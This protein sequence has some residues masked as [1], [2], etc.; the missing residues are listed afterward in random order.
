MKIAVCGAGAW[1]T[2]LALHLKRKQH[3]VHL[4]PRRMEHAEAIR[5]KEENV[6][7]LPG[8]KIPE[9]LPIYCQLEKLPDF[10]P[11]CIILACPSAGLKNLVRKLAEEFKNGTAP[12]LVSLAKGLDH[13]SLMTPADVIHNAWPSAAGGALSGPTFAGEV[14]EGKPTAIVL[15]TTLTQEKAE[16]F[17]KAINSPELRVYLSSDVAGVELGGCLKNIY[18]IAAGI[19][20]GLGLGD[21]ARAALITR[22][23]NEMIMLGCALGGKRETFFG[24]SGF[25]DLVA[26]CSGD[27][28]RNR[29]FGLSIGKGKKIEELMKDRKTVVEGYVATRT[30]SSLINDK[31]LE[32]P[33]LTE[34][35]SILYEGKAP[36]KALQSLMTRDLKKE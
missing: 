1:G 29:T 18:A 7:Y 32:T 28:S 10:Q 3:E 20:D 25:G 19:S 24:L 15:A 11:E 2:A 21:N 16:F 9:S 5:K 23:L 13:E 12:F 17:Q 26:T 4:L 22:S 8:F 30:V 33:I 14:A 36:E 31:N 34:V 35:K 27:W 6:D